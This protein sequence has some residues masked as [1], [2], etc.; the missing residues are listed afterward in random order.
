MQLA[1][2]ALAALASAFPVSRTNAFENPPPP[3]PPPPLPV[4][5]ADAA[6]QHEIG[7]D[8]FLAIGLLEVVKEPEASVGVTTL[9]LSMRMYEA[10]RGRE[11]LIVPG[12]VR[13]TGEVLTLDLTPMNTFSEDARIVVAGAGGEHEIAR[14]DIQCFTGRV[15]GQEDSRVFLA[16]SP[17]GTSGTIFASGE[18]SIISSG[19]RGLMPTVVFETSSPAA[20]TINFDMPT[21]GGARI[22]PGSGPDVGGDGGITDRSGTCRM[23]RIAVEADTEI[24][25]NLFGGNQT[26]AAAYVATL[27][28]GMN[29]IYQRDVNIA[30]ELS[31]LRLWVGE[32]PYDRPDGSQLDQFR[33]YWEAN[34]GSVSR[35]LAHFIS[36]RGLG[37]G[38]AWLGQICTTYSYASSG[39]LSGYF[40]YPLIDNHAQNWDMFVFAHESGHNLGTGHT[41][42][43]YTPVIDG[44]GNGDCTVAY[45]HNGTIMSY[46]HTCAGGMNNIRLQLG[47]RVADAIRA[48]VDSR[49]SCG[50]LPTIAVTRQP[51]DATVCPGGST[52]FS[53]G[54]IGAGTRTYQWRHNRIAILHA[55]SQSYA[56]VN[57]RATDAGSYDCVI[58]SSCTYLI[59]HTATL[60]VCAAD[61]NC[62]DAVDF[63]D[64]DD[65][66]AAFEAG[67]PAADFNHD[68]A[69]DFFDFDDFVARFEAGC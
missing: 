35:H 1:V 56:V 26:A 41:H 7:D 50:V 14:P 28:G 9:A 67:T 13:G 30:F 37:G 24:T 69:I 43:S 3:P 31:Y 15:M 64:Y 25:A 42:D 62:D 51:A 17:H 21:C 33:A 38:V 40:P 49:A 65:F 2:F 47:P 20:R 57:A 44:C 46:C 22:A 61:F 48:F 10:V 59:T 32:D 11:R 58:R 52:T 39:N 66:V 12:F 19:P 63:F 60:R 23:Y 45:Q 6:T 36:G 34:M 18:T 5:L 68:T 54:V 53:M 4:P 16:L 27:I 8:T 55:N 29:S